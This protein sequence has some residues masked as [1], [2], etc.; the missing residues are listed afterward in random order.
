MGSNQPSRAVLCRAL[1][2]CHKLTRG[3]NLR[4][5]TAEPRHLLL[6]GAQQPQRPT[7]SR[8]HCRRGFLSGRRRTKH[9]PARCA[10]PTLA[11]LRCELGP[12]G[13]GPGPRCD[14][15]RVACLCVLS[16]VARAR[17]SCKDIK[18]ARPL[19]TASNQ[20]WVRLKCTPAKRE[21][22]CQTGKALSPA[23]ATAGTSPNCKIDGPTAAGRALCLNW[24]W[25][26]AASDGTLL[27]TLV[28]G[29]VVIN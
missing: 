28:L 20:Q 15:F 23:A 19:R 22:S 26:W 5:D 18:S 6:E 27:L 4:P 17:H 11:V 1:R 21:A 12:T 29:D 9:A 24:V 3:H 25:P 8:E 2:P 10:S 13:T 14:R 7:F 16:F